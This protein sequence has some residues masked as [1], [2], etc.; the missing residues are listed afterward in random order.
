MEEV[1]K[2]PGLMLRGTTY[3]IRVHVPSDL[4]AVYAP[5]KELWRSLRV[6][7]FSEA[8]QKWRVEGLK[9]DQEF[10]RHR[11]RITATQASEA[12]Q[13]VQRILSDT[14]IERLAELY[15]FQRVGWDDE[16]RLNGLSDHQFVELD[17][18]V[19][20][21]LAEFR[22]GIARN[23]LSEIEPEM[24]EFLF[25]HE[26]D[27]PKDTEA[28]RRLAQ[29]IYKANIRS[30]EI[31]K[32]R[33]EGKIVETPKL[34][35]LSSS[36]PSLSQAFERWCVEH[37]GPQKT[38]DEF[39][40]QLT[41]FTSLHGDLPVD[42][43]TK[44]HVRDFKDAMLRFPA[45]LS[46]AERRLPVAEVLEAYEGKDVPRLSPQTINEKCLAA[47]K[48]VLGLCEN[49]G[50]IET[51]P[52]AGVRAKES[53]QS[54]V[55]TLPYTNEDLR[56]IL[57]WPIFTEG[58]RPKGG[59]G[60]AAKWLPLMAMFSGARL[61]ELA[62]LTKEDFGVEDGVRF[63]RLSGRVKNASSRRKIPVHSRL[64]E[65]GLLQYVEAIKA[66]PIFPLLAGESEKVSHS[67]SKWWG[68]Y[69]RAQ[70]LT[71]PKKVF[72]SFRHTVKRKMRD[73]GVDKTLR[74]AVMG[75]TAEDEAERYGRDEEGQ[76]FALGP[77]SQAIE[78]IDHP[79]L[80]QADLA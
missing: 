55:S 80:A 25:V 14:E 51:N 61:E 75:H 54:E 16:K 64:V 36:A 23:D 28:Y 56:L 62:S 3:Y 4:L 78:S 2:Y 8:I 35:P 71:D 7:S 21:A 77:L 73:A 47:L 37:R 9:V 1:R 10:A 59:G 40:A 26:I 19:D 72:H 53:N 50:L 39:L 17:S 11:A 52:A 12:A 63:M 48:A 46:N 32:A 69:A 60:E 45:R 22:R 15:F 68:R 31:I 18:N 65:L 79:A 57:S 30:L 70:G 67:W 44:A 49:D 42:R 29:A 20:E 74:D 38:V 58:F 76:G 66:G 24:E 13:P 5:K 33:N 43:I 27:L 6:Q 34:E 41:R